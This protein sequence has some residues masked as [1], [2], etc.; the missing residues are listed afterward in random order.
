MFT[1]G[2]SRGRFHSFIGRLNAVDSSSNTFVIQ[3]IKCRHTADSVVDGIDADV[4]G[5]FIKANFLVR[6]GSFDRF[7]DHGPNFSID[8]LPFVQQKRHITI[9]FFIQVVLDKNIFQLFIW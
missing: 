7:V 3:R 4:G 1:I 2:F 8:I 9:S 5:Q 6:L